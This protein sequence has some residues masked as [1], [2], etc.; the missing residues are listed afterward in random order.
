MRGSQIVT[1]GKIHGSA[2]EEYRP[3]GLGLLKTDMPLNAEAVAWIDSWLK[4][5][6]HTL[7]LH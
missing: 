6:N 4:Q 3:R 5:A 1:L 2:E 7:D